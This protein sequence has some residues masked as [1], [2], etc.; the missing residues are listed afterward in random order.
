M[1]DQYQ[2]NPDMQYIPVD[3]GRTPSSGY[4]DA[5]YRFLNE[6]IE[7]K[8]A[9]DFFIQISN[10]DFSAQCVNAFYKV[11]TSG[12]DKNSMLAK[13]DKKGIAMRILEFE[14]ALNL[15]V[16]ECHE[17]DI[18]NPAFLTFTENIR[19]AFRDFVS[20]SSTERDQL[21]RQEFITQQPQQ[22][23]DG[24]GQPITAMPRTGGMGRAG[25]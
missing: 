21:L 6:L 8:T 4:S 11:L 3:L 24:Q 13:N 15:M 9:R 16:V 17:S 19:Q 23:G 12:F 1:P 7:S 5:H 18:Q 22:R 25:Q 10:T 20:R 2:P 14:I